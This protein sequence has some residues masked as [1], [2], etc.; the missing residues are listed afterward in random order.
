MPAVLAGASSLVG[1]LA[2]QVL[3]AAA[4]A[5][6]QMCWHHLR[7]LYPHAGLAFSDLLP[8]WGHMHG[9]QSS[10]RLLI[11]TDLGKVT[12][13][14][15]NLL[16]LFASHNFDKKLG[17]LRSKAYRCSG[18]NCRLTSREGKMSKFTKQSWQDKAIRLVTDL[19]FVK[20]SSKDRSF[21]NLKSRPVRYTGVGAAGHVNVAQRWKLQQKPRPDK[22]SEV[23]PDR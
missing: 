15:G 12:A 3:Q 6:R 20:S 16:P 2:S 19:R 21:R 10:A 17:V 5:L 22:V 9:Q 8:D 1:A 7:L 14:T 13:S 23:S 11:G 4:L 18:K